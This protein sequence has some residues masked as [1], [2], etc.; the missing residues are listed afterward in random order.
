[1]RAFGLGLAIF[2]AALAGPALGADQTE[3]IED[4]E[5]PGSEIEIDVEGGKADVHR[6]SGAP[7][8]E[9][10]G[11]GNSAPPDAAFPSAGDPID[12][13]LPGEGPENLSGPDDDDPLPE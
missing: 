9:L 1:M 10:G 7:I 3:K 12:N 8:L 2:A 11:E 4:S 6:K 5:M 13:E